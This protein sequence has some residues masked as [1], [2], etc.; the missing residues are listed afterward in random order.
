MQL[1]HPDSGYKLEK[2]NIGIWTFLFGPLYFLGSEIYNQAI[3]M[4]ILTGAAQAFVLLVFS[5]ELWAVAIAILLV[6]GI[7]ATLAEALVEA[8]YRRHGWTVV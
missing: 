4:A 8:H 3:L 7:Y 1:K 6:H 2:N 5:G